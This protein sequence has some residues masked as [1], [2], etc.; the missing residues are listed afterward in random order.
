MN[1]QR[2]EAMSYYTTGTL[3]TGTDIGTGTHIYAN[4]DVLAIEKA[5]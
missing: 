2:L 1:V 4:N 3:R 5:F